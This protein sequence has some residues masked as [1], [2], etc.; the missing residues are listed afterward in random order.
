MMMVGAAGVLLAAEEAKDAKAA[1]PKEAPFANPEAAAVLKNSNDRAGYA[2]GVSLANSMKRQGAELNMELL[3]RALDDV[4]GGKSTLLTEAESRTVMMDYQKEM[5]SK[6]EAKRKEQGV[7]NKKEATAF[8]AENRN[9][10]GVKVHA[11][12]LDDGKVA[13]MQYKILKVGTGPTPKADDTAITHYRGTLI[14]GTEFDSSHKRGK[15]AEFGVGGV[16]K[17]WTTALQMMPVGS[18]WQLFLPPELAYGERGAGGDIGPNAALIFEIELV[19]IKEKAPAAAGTGTPA[20]AAAAQNQNVVTSDIIKV[21][22]ADELKKGAKIEVIK[23]SDL[24]RIQKETKEAAKPG[25][26]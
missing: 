25:A 24:E 12:K 15:P 21:P 22:S 14:N 1:A 16:I 18:K 9:K 13:E 23:A 6:A 10:E 2:Y 4:L 20:P 26:K 11:V 7:A 5:R 17:G 19:G 3:K 8:L